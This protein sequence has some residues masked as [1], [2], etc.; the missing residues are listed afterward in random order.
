MKATPCF[1]WFSSS[2]LE[3]HSNLAFAIA[4]SYHEVRQIAIRLYGL[5]KSDLSWP[6]PKAGISLKAVCLDSTYSLRKRAA[7]SD[8]R[9]SG[10]AYLIRAR[11]QR[12]PSDSL[13]FFLEGVAEAALDCAHRTSTF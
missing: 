4:K 5:C 7:L 13:Q 11:I 9:R 2:F 3:S 8:L 12:V 6:H 1:L 10:G